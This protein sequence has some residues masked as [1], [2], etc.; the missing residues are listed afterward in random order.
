MTSKKKI[1][2]LSG[3]K[4]GFDAMLPFLKLIKEKNDFSLKVILTDQHLEKKFGETYKECAGE[5]GKKYIKIIKIFQKNDQAISRTIGMSILLKNLS[6]YINKYKPNL[7]LVYGDRVE[8]LISAIV[9]LNFNIPICHFQGGD[10]SGNIDEKIRHSIT[11]LSD[12]HLT[13]NH[14]SLSRVIK[15]GENKSSSFAIGDSHVDSLYKL[16][17]GKNRF[18]AIK[19]KYELQ[20]KYVVFLMHPDGF[21]KERNQKF[22]H[23]ALS[24]LKKVN[25]QTICIYPCT[26]IGYQGIILELKRFCKKNKRFKVYKTIRHHD[27]VNLLKNCLFFIGNSSSGIIESSYLKIPFINLGDRQKGRLHASNVVHSKFDQKSILRV[28]KKTEKKKFQKKLKT[29]SFLYGKGKSYLR[30]YNIIKKKIGKISTF[31]N[32]YE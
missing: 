27:F 14:Q 23:Q 32:F 1:V 21:S 3:K 31:K 25:L 20:G 29:V 24:A 16:K 22:C 7:F 5:I 15:M 28:I 18:N 17:V 6:N 19:K 26:D 30:A 12:L 10:L 9:A 4:G 13:S 2:F 8:S 11:K